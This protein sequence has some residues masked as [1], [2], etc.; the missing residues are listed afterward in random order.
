MK[1]SGKLVLLSLAI[2]ALAGCR[3][4]ANAAAQAASFTVSQN[5]HAVGTASY[6]FTGVS[7]GY[8]STSLGNVS[9]QGLN[10]AL[11]KDEQLNSA[12]HLQHV[13][14][15]G[16]VNGAAVN[17]TAKPDAAQFLL[18]IS[19]NGRSS[20]TRLA[21]HPAAVLL[22][23]FDPGAL[24][25][26]LVRIGGQLDRL[27]GALQTLL[28]LA[29]EQNNRD[30]WAIVPKEQGSIQPIQLATYPDQQGT[31]NG[32]AVTVH[33]LVATI[34]GA[35]T[36]LF[37]SQENELMQAELPG[38]GFALVRSGFVLTPPAKPIAPPTPPTQ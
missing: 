31:L 35:H 24:Q 10:Y 7:G 18:N 21:S 4:R 34:S 33:H 1:T 8:A 12:S 17:V 37:S 25:T 22:P 14:L 32:K 27:D 29:V 19:A 6:K 28:V 13:G 9:M 3:S 38:E 16:T 11:S 5:G 2:F 15:S 26:L 36:D 30:L 20:T 23:D